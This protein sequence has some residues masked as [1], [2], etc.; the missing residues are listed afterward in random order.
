MKIFADDDIEEM[1]LKKKQQ[2]RKILTILLSNIDRF[3]G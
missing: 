1:E 3:H 2:K